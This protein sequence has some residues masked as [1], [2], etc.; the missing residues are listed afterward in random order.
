MSRPRC[1]RDAAATPPPTVQARGWR[2]SRR[3]LAADHDK[4]HWRTLLRARSCAVCVSASANFPVRAVVG[5]GPVRFRL[6]RG[7]ARRDK[8]QEQLAWHELAV[9]AIG[10]DGRPLFARQ[11][12]TPL[13][14][15][16]EGF[17]SRSR[18]KHLGLL[19]SLK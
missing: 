15:T 9:D 10:A 6:C 4:P 8:V 5:S 1:R 3:A 17:T 11:F 7:C 19:A 13:F 18:T 12:H 14:G 2:L 16:C